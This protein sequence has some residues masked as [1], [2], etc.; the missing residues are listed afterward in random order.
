MKNAFWKQTAGLLSGKPVR[1]VP[2]VPVTVRGLT[3]WLTSLT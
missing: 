3:L 1:Q 2:W